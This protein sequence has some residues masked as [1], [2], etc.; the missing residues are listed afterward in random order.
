MPTDV[1][2]ETIRDVQTKPITEYQR[3]QLGQAA[4]RLEETK[5]VNDA[6]IDDMV[7]KRE[8][9][10][11]RAEELKRMDSARIEDMASRGLIRQQEANERHRMDDARIEDMVDKR[12]LSHTKAIELRRMDDARIQN[13]A[14]R[15]E[16]TKERAKDLH[17]LSGARIKALERGPGEPVDEDTVQYWGE[18]VRRGE[19]LPATYRDAETKKRIMVAAAHGAG[20]QGSPHT[21]GEDLA[22]KAAL[23]SD[24]LSMGQLTKIADAA[25]AYENTALK[26]IEIVKQTMP[27]GIGL[28]GIPALDRWV[29]TG[30]VE[31]G[32]PNVPPY[33]TALVT[34]ANEYAKVMEGST[35]SQAVTV[36]A[37]EEAA[38]LLNQAQTKDQV[39]NVLGVMVKD[40]ENKKAAY[41]DQRKMISDRISVGGTTGMSTPAGTPAA[42][43][44]GAR[45]AIK[46]DA[47]GNR[48]Q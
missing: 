12:E 22:N 4:T 47:Q 39:T 40:M 36:S 1:L 44:E 41:K 32:D 13:M 9:S 7:G 46:Y 17:D 25:E 21:A 10:R 38:K 45:P 43:P 16:I 29:Q 26:N 15:G 24:T 28:T 30:R 11:D 31:T 42:A 6:R 27:K 20:I 2:L 8:I 14:D 37:R 5:R 23:R 18:R 34:V 48:V 33:Q 19:P 3:G 35:G